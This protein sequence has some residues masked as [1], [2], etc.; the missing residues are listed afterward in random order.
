MMA[1]DGRILSDEAARLTRLPRE[2]H[3]HL[4]WAL[5]QAEIGGGLVHMA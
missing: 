3:S 5:W 1:G 2:V 4:G